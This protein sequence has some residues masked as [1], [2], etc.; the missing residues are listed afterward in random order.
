MSTRPRPRV[1]PR[2]RTRVRTGLATATLTGAIAVALAGCGEETTAGEPAASTSTASEPVETEDSPQTSEEASE[3]PSESA[4]ESTE[5]EATTV[6]VY[7]VGETAQGPRLFREFQQIEGVDPLTGAANL[8]ASGDARDPDY[9]SLFPAGAFSAVD[10][11][12]TAFVAT[13]ADDTWTERGDLSEEQA[14]LAVQQLVYT[15][16]GVQ[17]ERAPL[18]VELDGRATTLLGI[19]TSRGVTNAPP[20]D[21]LALVNV[22]AP[23]QGAT[24]SGSFTASGRASSFEANVP[25]QVRRGDA[26]VLEGFATA[27]G[28][29]DKLY[30]WETTVDVSGLDAGEYTFVAMTDDPSGG[31][32]GP[33]ATEDTRTIVVE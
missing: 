33:G 15:L 18:R 14:R 28:W 17:Q 31:A 19:D 21:V 27:A 12:G 4:S 20:L 32:E 5:F 9:R 13:L 30:P 16:Q 10:V 2:A 26:V 24:V 23:A 11:E 7:F 3:T 8:A 29:M 1:R 22:T 25:W 6:P